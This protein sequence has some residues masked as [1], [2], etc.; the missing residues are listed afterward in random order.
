MSLAFM[1]RMD[2]MSA[3]AGA[4]SGRMSRMDGMSAKAGAE[5]GLLF[6]AQRD[7]LVICHKPNHA[8]FAL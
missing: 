7:H 6:Q 1:S 3:E 4:E 5:S 2:G 8:S